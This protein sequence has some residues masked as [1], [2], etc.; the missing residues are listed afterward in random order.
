MTTDSNTFED[1]YILVTLQHLV[2][3]LA[4]DKPQAQ[5]LDKYASILTAFMRGKSVSVQPTSSEQNEQALKHQQ[6]LIDFLED[7]IVTI[8]DINSVLAKQDAK[9]I[10]SLQAQ[11]TVAVEAL[12][13]VKGNSYQQDIGGGDVGIVTCEALEKVTEALNTINKMQNKSAESKGE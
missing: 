1:D 12:D 5:I 13:E 3:D 11:L 9:T 2:T 7:K 6:S 10:E 8:K 4:T